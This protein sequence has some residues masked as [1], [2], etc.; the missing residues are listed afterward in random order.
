MYEGETGSNPIHLNCFSALYITIKIYT[1][2]NMTIG[3]SSLY[4]ICMYKPGPAFEEK[5]LPHIAI[6]LPLTHVELDIQAD[7]IVQYYNHG[8]V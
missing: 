4:V 5:G 7:G 8:F 6:L 1:S 2:A 3:T